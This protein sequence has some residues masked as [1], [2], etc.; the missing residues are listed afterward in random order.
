MVSKPEEEI[1]ISTGVLT[2]GLSGLSTTPKIYDAFYDIISKAR[3]I[4]I[5]EESIKY[6][7]FKDIN[8]TIRIEGHL[9][10][11]EN[12]IKLVRQSVVSTRALKELQT[13]H[14][15]SRVLGEVKDD[16][17][18]IY[19][20]DGYRFHLREF[21]IAYVQQNETIMHSEDALIG[22][23]LSGAKEH[24]IGGLAGTLA[25]EITHLWHTKKSKANEFRIKNHYRF[26]K[27]SKSS[28]K[29]VRD[30]YEKAKIL[31][32]ILYDSHD[33]ENKAF[34]QNLDYIIKNLRAFYVHL[35]QL[36]ITFQGKLCTEGM[37]NFMGG[38][39]SG[40]NDYREMDRSAIG[41]AIALA[42]GFNHFYDA[43]LYIVNHLRT[44]HDKLSTDPSFSPFSKG[45]AA[46]ANNTYQQH[47]N[48]IGT[49]IDLFEACPYIIGPILPATL[50]YQGNMTIEEIGSLSPNQMMKKYVRVCEEKSIN[51]LIVN[52]IFHRGTFNISRATG[53]FNKLRK[54]LGI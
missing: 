52:S 45:H 51:P 35:R 16:I 8:L 37:A 9:T 39:V 11:L 30:L 50:Y 47:M 27:A 1:P 32:R 29:E 46:W 43:F 26:L 7:G 38:Y 5:I 17:I 2:I 34:K 36:F 49:F 28:D 14:I 4:R 44:V 41:R 23:I 12:T 6:S 10:D 22:Y 33:T 21:C 31:F 18:Y 54:N 19:F 40:S 15:P 42:D 20:T 48:R 13:R 3:F 53:E 25:H 24:Y